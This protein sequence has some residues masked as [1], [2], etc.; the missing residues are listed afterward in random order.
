MDHV[1]PFQCSR[2]GTAWGLSLNQPAAQQSEVDAQL[3]LRRKLYC[4]ELVEGEG[5]MDQAEPSQ[6]SVRVC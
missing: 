2:R 6:C 1:E 3:T 4:E 5:I